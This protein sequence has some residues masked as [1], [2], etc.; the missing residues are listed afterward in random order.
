MYRGTGDYAMGPMSTNQIIN[1]GGGP[2]QQQIAVNPLNNSGDIYISHTEFVQN[3]FAPPPTNG[4][5]G[6][7]PFNLVSF[8]INP[9]LTTTFPFLSQLAQNF[10]LYSLEG[11]IFQYKPQSGETN[12]TSNS[13]GQVLFATNYDPDATPFINSV[14]MANY[15]YAN[16]T[17]PS[18]GMVHGV[19]T[20]KSQQALK[21]SYVRTGEA[22]RDKIFTDIGLFQVATE[23]VPFSAGQSAQL[24]GQLWVS[25]RIR[26]SRANL[27]GSLLGQNIAQDHVTLTLGKTNVGAVAPVYKATNTLGC[28]ITPKNQ[29]GTNPYIEIA[30]PVSISLGSYRILIKNEGQPGGFYPS[31]MEL[32]SLF[33]AKTWIPG[34]ALPESSPTIPQQL[35]PAV[36]SGAV[37]PKGLVIF[38]T[39]TAPGDLIALLQVGL[40]APTAGTEK[41]TIDITQINQ[42]PSLTLE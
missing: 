23:G 26:L 13:L 14:E 22:Q 25:Y 3:I 9:G 30:F 7:S 1:G 27:Y 39:I 37:G 34:T 10:S 12:L 15:D 2:A 36:G 18:L 21:M 20:A 42:I 33:N 17:K 19:E 40:V 31:D 32:A 28:T 11:L 24:L 8:A 6:S 35:L 4:L 29:N 38:V 16:T 5:A 41:L